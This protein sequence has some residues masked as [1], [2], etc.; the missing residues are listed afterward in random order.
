MTRPT[1]GRRR[2]G[3]GDECG[4]AALE[5][6]LVVP[7]VLAAF[8]GVLQYGYHFW[9]LETAAA[10]AREAVRRVAV[11]TDWTCTA[12]R[13]VEHASMPALDTGPPQ[14]TYSYENGATTPVVGALATV[15]VRFRSLDIGLLPV[16]HDGWVEQSATARVESVPY[17]PLGC[18]APWPP[19]P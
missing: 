15:T 17:T 1:R 14:V 3:H 18:D 11:G 16:P 19:S 4:A 12:Q 7:L 9:S 6:G 13:A 8:F 10:T 2:G 5:F